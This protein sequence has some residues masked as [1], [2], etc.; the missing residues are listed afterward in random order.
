MSRVAIVTGAGSG[1]GR[2]M[3]LELVRRG[4][5]LVAVDLDADRLEALEAEA[6]AQSGSFLAVPTDISCLADCRSAVERAV[7]SFGG[8]DI[9]INCAGVSM[10]PA[11]PPGK[12]HPVKFWE[13]DPDGWQKIQA[14][15]STGPYLMTRFAVEHMLAKG[16]GRIVNVTTSFD[17]MLA[18]GMSAYGASKAALEASSAIW[19]KELAGSGVTVNVV[20]PGGMTDTP[21]LPAEARKPGLLQ[22]E[23]MAPVVAWLVSPESD[24]INGRRFVAKLWDPSVPPSEA[25]AAC[26]EPI[27][28]EAQAAVATNSR[29][30]S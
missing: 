2:A 8:I 9:L 23:I 15:N 7:R 13:T 21:F 25:A 12:Q 18:R 10:A 6:G 27:A 28:W 11:T 1:M 24:G 20:V 17:T 4:T 3:A 19:A 14:I 16:W 29:G 5:K 22:P 26:S 30:V